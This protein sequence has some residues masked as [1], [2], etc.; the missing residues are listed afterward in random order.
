MSIFL[1]NRTY[2]KKILYI[3]N[4]KKTQRLNDTI[5]AIEKKTYFKEKIN[6]ILKRALPNEFLAKIT[7]YD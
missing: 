6:T 3:W 5:Q 1:L 7:K 4:K 2:V